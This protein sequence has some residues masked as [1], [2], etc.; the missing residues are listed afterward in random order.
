[1]EK[2][3]NKKK[4]GGYPAIGVVISTTLALFV[5]GLFGLLIIYSTQ[6]EK[7]VRQNIRLQV[8][9]R[10][11]IT[12]T[13]RLQIEN[14]ILSQDYAYKEKGKAIVFVPKDVA[15]KEL[16]AQTGEDFVK[17][18]GEN[19][20]KDAYLVSIDPAYHSKDQIEKIMADIAKM[21]GVFDVFYIK[22]LIEKVN[23][24]A[25]RIGFVLS[26][27]IIILLITVV[28]LINNTLRLAMFS[29]RFLIRSMQLV[30]AKNGFIQR[31]FL[32]R[33]AGYGIIS[34]IIAAVILYALSDYAQ[35]E[36]TELSEVHN[37][38]Q[39]LVLICIMLLLGIIVA[40]VSTYFS[41]QKYLR[42]SLDQLY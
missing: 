36:V 24:N 9:L 21:N 23:D 42:M 17:L 32:F 11:N 7:Q 18:I 13:Q 19:P 40:V 15:A 3:T 10:S 39:F 8:Y 41:I 16:I 5:I 33:A 29:Q 38:D 30:G 26:G 20:L 12:E 37:Q 25:M 28:L 35:R 14:K 31:P 2:T 6:L 34:G 4:L 22:E 1:M 27:V